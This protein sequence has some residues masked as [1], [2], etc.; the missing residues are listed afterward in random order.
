MRVYLKITIVV[1]IASGLITSCWHEQ[2]KPDTVFMKTI[3]QYSTLDSS[4][5]TIIELRPRKVNLGTISRNKIIEGSFSIINK[6]NKN[7]N[8]FE[9]KPNCDCL[10]LSYNDTKII[11]P[12]DS[13]LVKY[14]LDV[15]S[16]YKLIS[17]SIVV[18][19]NCQ[20]GNQTFII[21]AFVN[22]K[23]Q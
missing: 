19:G 11:R 22:Q 23:V 16:Y 20:F 15:H 8:I 4:L 7:F 21:Q 14:V 18:I 10:S 2:S 17:Q 1:I 6:G 12:H 5:K 9:I 3:E 13:L